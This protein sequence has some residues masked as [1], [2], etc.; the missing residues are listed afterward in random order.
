MV[1]K[2]EFTEKLLRMQEETKKRKKK[3]SERVVR[4]YIADN[5]K[6]RSKGWKKRYYH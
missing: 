3:H 1:T 6:K 4:D 5:C 2:E